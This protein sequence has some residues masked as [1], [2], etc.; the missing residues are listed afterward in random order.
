MLDSAS[1]TY[2]DKSLTFKLG[3]GC[4]RKVLQI[5]FAA[6]RRDH[7]RGRSRLPDLYLVPESRHRTEADSRRRRKRWL[8]PELSFLSSGRRRQRQS[9]GFD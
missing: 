1:Y 8:L 3:K 4:P 6:I 7:P 5:R 2:L 9:T